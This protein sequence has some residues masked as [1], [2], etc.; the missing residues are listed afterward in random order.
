M[1]FA[2]SDYLIIIRDFLKLLKW[3]SFLFLP[4]L[5]VALIF[6]EEVFWIFMVEFL[7]ILALGKFTENLIKVE[8][9]TKFKHAFILVGLIWLFVAGL[10][11]LP[12]LFLGVG[13]VDAFFESVSALTTTGFTI[14]LNL[15]NLPY[16]I[17]FWRSF[18]QWIG[19]IGIV[20][21]VLGG[22]F[23]IGGLAFYIAEGR[24]E[25]IKPNII[26]TVKIIWKIYIFYTLLGI[27]M[28]YLFGMPLF[29]SVNHAMTAIATGGM[30]VRDISQYSFGIHLT[31]MVL[32]LLGA[33][34][35]YTHY[36]LFSRKFGEALKDIQLHFLIFL[37]LF[38]FFILAFKSSAYF[39][40]LFHVI[41]AITCTGFGLSPLSALDDFSKQ[42]LIGLMV[43]GGA[44]G[45]TAG[46]IKIIRLIVILKSIKLQLKKIL[47]PN[48]V[49]YP[50]IYGK[51]IED[52]ASKNIF[53]FVLAY[54]LL[55]GFGS[56]VLTFIGYPLID[57]LFEVASAQGNVGL[58][59]GIAEKLPSLGKIILIINM[60]LGRLEIWAMLVLGSLI[61]RR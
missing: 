42:V 55:L 52:E 54:L 59:V 49:E 18:M 60:L 30:S 22:A 12:F 57:A 1:I 35:F 9:D 8:K 50:K 56:M 17:L 45:S 44:A 38:S 39:E 2:K 10:A 15:D 21:A 26:N 53:L 23:R 31:L 41:S 16:S 34:S 7:S 40:N 5:V 4:P 58:S 36:L 61:F 25:K 43:I 3:I 6:R 48:L 27:L 32:M 11:S 33:T 37:I 28:L 51:I 24:E 20:V 29:D 47:T 14:F 19:G 46:G 13:F